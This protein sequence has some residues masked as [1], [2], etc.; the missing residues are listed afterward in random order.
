MDIRPLKHATPVG[1][2]EKT[3]QRGFQRIILEVEG[4]GE[5]IQKGALDVVGESQGDHNVVG[6]LGEWSPMIATV[7]DSADRQ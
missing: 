7:R 2:V 3:E 6:Y 5:V 4:G 1:L